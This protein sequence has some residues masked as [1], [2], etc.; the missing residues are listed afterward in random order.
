LTYKKFIKEAF[1]KTN[2]SNA[3]NKSNIIF[4]VSKDPNGMHHIHRVSNVLTIAPRRDFESSFI[5]K[6]PILR[7]DEFVIVYDDIIKSECIDKSLYETL[8]RYKRGDGHT[9][10][11]DLPYISAFEAIDGGFLYCKDATTPSVRMSL[12]YR[13]FENLEDTQ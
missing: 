3:K 1:M 11:N 2:K 12:S 9:P 5:E 6:N 10:F 4:K 13:L 7:Q 8:V